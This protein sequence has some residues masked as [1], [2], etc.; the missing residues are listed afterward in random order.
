MTIHRREFL[1]AMRTAAVAAACA[2]L[3]SSCR[4]PASSA[5]SGK[6]GQLPPRGAPDS[7]IVSTCGACPGGCGIRA[8]LASGRLVGIAGNP[9]HPINRGGLC[10]LGLAGAQALYHPD[11]VRG[12]LRRTGAGGLGE[13]R[14]ASWEEGLAAVSGRLRDLRARGMAH[15]V[16]LVDGTRG[17]SREVA[18]R[19]LAAYGSPNHLEGRP[20]NDVS[21]SEAVRAMQGVDAAAAYDLE[22]ARFILAF[23][24]GW[25]EGAA[26]PVG[27][28]RAFG[29]ARRGRKSGRVHVVHVEP[30]LSVSAAH[31][32]EWIPIQPGTEGVLALG[33]M[34]MV[35]REGL[36]SRDF[37]D[38]WG[39]GFDWLRAL[40]LRDYH[41]DA[42]SERTGVP[43]ASI[44]RLARQF[45]S[46]RPAVAIGDDRSGPGVQ[47]VEAGMAIH[48]LNAIGGSI[49]APGGV[50]TPPPVPLDPLPPAPGDERGGRGRAF[51]PVAGGRAGSSL[52]ALQ[53]WLEGDGS[54]PINA[55]I[56]YGADPL[57]A[58]GGGERAQAAL[59]RVPFVVSFSSF[60]DDTAS[61]ADLVLPDHTYLER[62]Q[63]DPT[64][65]SRG[66]PV[67][68]LRQPVLEPRH[69]TRHA[70]EVLAGIARGVGGP[71][72]E[73]LP[74]RDFREVIR[75]SVRGIHRSG[76][77]ALFDVPEAEAWVE[78]MEKNGWRA[79]NFG[80]FDEFWAGLL[81]RG[82]WWDPVYDFGERGRVLRTASRKLDFGPLARA[83]DF[84]ASHK[85][86]AS[87][88][89][90]AAVGAPAGYPLRLH[91]YPLL[92]AFGDMQGPL[93]FVQ[94]ALGR[95]MRQ[96]WSLW[97]E[98]APVDAAGLGIA[99]GAR[100]RVESDAG[101]VEARAKV[102]PGVRPGVVAMPVGPG[103]APGRVCRRALREQA[104]VLVGLRR[105]PAGSTPA[106]GDA[107]VRIHSA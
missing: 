96:S 59:R 85:E 28:A 58:L 107:W 25:L 1:K 105:G 64:R 44:I 82:G 15:T 48:A 66:F 2:P 21:P 100:V 49:N 62:W 13:L 97:V 78:T 76:R 47:S 52:A 26:S 67:L 104:G 68:G 75:L 32:D 19:F 69:D 98:I 81:A 93:P 89:G 91:L 101:A 24:S 72:G 30:R 34:H 79:S 42:V 33:L 12:P 55:L 37:I 41:P 88:G 14:P 106:L 36:E 29:I 23:G 80:T 43:V 99:D 31:A 4:R 54:Y 9:L 3:L 5:A 83:L 90:P 92:A 77:G 20:W 18:G 27:A 45:A 51:P 16:A 46:T 103:G 71:A 38:Q 17:L 40:V 84:R 35:L 8:R 61:Q 94:D 50:L 53:A 87:P 74:W 60:L 102:Y 86:P 11:R 73:A 95:E 7:W 10:P 70:A 65:T 57:A 63:D 22:N 56:A 6:A 39:F